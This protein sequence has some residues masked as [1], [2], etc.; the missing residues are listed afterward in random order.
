M[1]LLHVLKVSGGTAT[2]LVRACLCTQEMCAQ[3]VDFTWM[4][5]LAND[6]QPAAAQ[7]FGG[8]VEGLTII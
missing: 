7:S 1:K 5:V 2:P 8:T 6:L 3:L 4:L